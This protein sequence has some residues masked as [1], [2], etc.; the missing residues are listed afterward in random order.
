[1]IFSK[2]I[3]SPAPADIIAWADTSGIKVD[4]HSFDSTRTPQLVEPIRAMADADTRIGTLIKPVQVGGSTAGEIVCAYWSA[5][6]NG[7]IQYNWQD[8]LKAKD[9]WNDRILPTLESCRDIKRTGARHEEMICEARY[10]NTTVRVQGVFN[11]S[12]LDSD[13]VPLQI[14]EEIHLWK[15]GFLS[16]AR[17]R[18]TQVW[19]AKAFDISNASNENDQLH[20]TYE[21]GTQET[22]QVVCPR[23]G[24][25]HDMH[26]RFNPNKPELGGLR[27]DSD[28][29]KMEGGRFNYNKLESSIRYQFP[30][31]HEIKDHASERRRLKGSYSIPRNE[32]AHISHRSWNFEAVSC[33]AIR[34][35]TLIQEWHSAIRAMKAGDS[36]PMRRFVTERECKFYSDQSRPFQGQVVINTSR[37]KDR[38]GLPGRALRAWAAD[39][40]KGY[41]ALGQLSHYWLVIRDVLENCDS[42]LVWEGLVQTDTDLIAILDEHECQRRHGVVDATWDT[43]HVME[44]CYRNG[45][46]AVQGS[47][48]Q[49]WFTHLDKTKRFYSVPKP[50]HVELNTVPRFNYSASS[51]GWQPSVDEPMVWH[52]NKAGLLSNLF[53]LRNHKTNTLTAN[54][55][56]QPWEYITHDVPGD[57]S[58]DYKLQNDS[59][60]RRQATRGRAQ[61]QIEEW[62]Q[63]RK[64]DHMLLCEGY[65]GMMMDIGGFISEKLVALGIK[66]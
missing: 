48:K 27:W 58:E 42:E 60:E 51:A 34:W 55:D 25:P 12:S 38:A 10:V 16:K 6:H 14:N 62:R 61:E 19:N 52:Y 45:L 2:S 64:D 46:N 22:W 20:S 24:Q 57:V 11:E 31:G 63:T 15:P 39:K 35:L 40:Q 47:A 18:Q 53:F 9:R 59:W 37:K 49:E 8:D 65:I 32:G 50:I 54:P 56:A 44:F 66:Q 36:E 30:C 4:G 33:D 41:R 3:P 13:T 5:Y 17:R 7:L 1:M 28:G 26:F 23:C 29:C 21:D 43:K